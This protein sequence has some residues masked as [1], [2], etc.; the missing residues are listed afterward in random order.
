MEEAS[1]CLDGGGSCVGDVGMGRAEEDL[2]S[3]DESKLGR[4]VYR[5]VMETSGERLWGVGVGERMLGVEVLAHDAYK[6]LHKKK[7]KTRAEIALFKH[8]F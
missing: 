5:E 3:P 4:F 7:K 1:E 2:K 6:G 8:P